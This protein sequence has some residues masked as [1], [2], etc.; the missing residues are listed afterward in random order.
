MEIVRLA[1][2][3][4]APPAALFGAFCAVAA[5]VSRIEDR[6]AEDLKM[7]TPD[8]QTPMLNKTSE[9]SDYLQDLPKAA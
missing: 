7:N 4:L 8:A 9:T 3:V 6:S 1:A 5:L 2:Y